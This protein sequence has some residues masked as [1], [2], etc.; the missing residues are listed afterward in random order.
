MR[1]LLNSN[2]V[3]T[4][5]PYSYIYCFLFLLELF[6]NSITWVSTSAG[7]PKFCNGYCSKKR[8][9]HSYV[10]KKCMVELSYI[11]LMPF[12]SGKRLGKGQ[13]TE[14]KRPVVIF[15]SPV[16]P[17]GPFS[18]SEHVYIFLEKVFRTLH[19][20]TKALSWLSEVSEHTVFKTRIL[21]CKFTWLPCIYWLLTSYNTLSKRPGFVN[22]FVM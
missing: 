15:L 4:Q 7:A 13:W 6:I 18:G 12:Y 2:D 21:N 10:S 22:L 19:C 9:Q 14:R 16:L 11:T 1:Q 20:I 8:N 5:T 3:I 17:L